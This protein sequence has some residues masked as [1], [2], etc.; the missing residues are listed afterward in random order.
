MRIADVCVNVPIKGVN[1]IFSYGVP[2]ELNYIDMGWRVTV[3]FGAQT[4]DGFIMRVYE[5]DPKDFDFEIKPIASAVD[6]EAWFTPLMI[7]TAQWLANFYLCPLS[8]TMTLFMPGRISRKISARFEK[9]IEPA[10]E[11]TDDLLSTFKNKRA[12]LKILIELRSKKIL[13]TVGINREPLKRLLDDG[14]IVEGQRRVLRDSYKS[15][16]PLEKIIE[17]TE[18]QRHA[19]DAISKA[20]VERKYRGFLLNGVTGSGKTQVYIELTALVRRLG[21]GAVILVPEIA[22]TGQIVME[23]KR[24]FSDVI[25]LHSGLSTGERADAFHKIRN[26]D[27]G[28]VIGARSALFTPLDNIGLFVLDEEQDHSYKQNEAPYYHAQIVAEEFARLH[29]APIVFGSAT[30]SLE[31]YYRALNGELEMLKLSKR[32]DERPLPTVE[33]VDMREELK[34]RNRNVLSRSLLGLLKETLERGEQ[35]ILMLNRRGYSTFVMCRS[36]GYVVDCADCGL[37]M[38]YHDDGRLRCHRCDVESGPPTVCPKCG[39]KYIKYFGSGTQK[40]E[41][42]L[43]ELLPTARLLR[44]DR[45]T[46]TKKFAHQKMLDQFRAHEFDILLG[47]QM[48]AKG[49]DIAGVTAVGILSA[50]SSLNIPDFRSSETCFGLITQA[51]GRAG[52]STGLGRVIVQAYNPDHAAIFYGCRQDYEGF[53]ESELPKR[54]E[55]FYPPFSRLIKLLLTGKNEEKIKARALEIVEQFRAEFEGREGIRAEIMGPAA[56][57]IA[58]LK[59]VYRFVLLIKTNDLDRARAFLRANKLHQREDVTVDIDPI[60]IL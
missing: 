3:P 45:D 14:L 50:D 22:L 40:L 10:V 28:V 34:A 57:M 41:Q 58:R 7:I 35:A 38:V 51:A 26:G 59:D 29:G 53:F 37:P 13:P 2:D 54:E 33:C 15:I 47:T 8:Q 25:V 18:E 46:T 9:I 17:L 30:P 21:R 39:S 19:I 36:C 5:G 44:M 48:V 6:D 11:I 4:V 52:R 49:H 16:R 23:F 55:L 56:A 31:N 27:A 1:Q 60:N 24:R 32:I 43:K 12:Q 42:A 20:I